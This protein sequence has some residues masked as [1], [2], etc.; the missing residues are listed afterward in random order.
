M[1]K[2]PRLSPVVKYAIGGALVIGVFV[3]FFKQTA[4]VFQP[5]ARGQ[6]RIRMYRGRSNYRGTRLG[7][8]RSM[9]NLAGNRTQR[10]SQRHATRLMRRG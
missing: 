8:K 7:N 6:D 5:S 10:R 9:R 4:S 1:A 2:K 3:F